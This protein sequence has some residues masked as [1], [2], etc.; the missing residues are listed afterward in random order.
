MTKE[1]KAL[2]RIETFLKETCKHYKQDV[3]YIREALQRLESI[4]NANPSE[5]LEW[6]GKQWV[7]Y[8][9]QDTVMQI[10][11]TKE[12]DTIKQALLKAQEQEKVLE[13]IINKNVEMWLL[14]DSAT[15]EQY[16]NRIHTGCEKLTQNEFDLLKR[17][18]DEEK[19]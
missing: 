4:D 3:G 7:E 15:L 18:C 9:I 14:K 13:I 10:K 19:D 11:N 17:Y 1:L 6:F 16:N 2:E 5:A 12:Y 8:G